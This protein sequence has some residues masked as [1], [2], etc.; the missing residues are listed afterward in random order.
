VESQIESLQRAL[1]EANQPRQAVEVQM[2]A[3]AEALATLLLTSRRERL[4]AA[5]TICRGLL[6]FPESHAHALGLRDLWHRAKA[7]MEGLGK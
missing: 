3:L 4:E 5:E 7:F 1:F 2:A 6:E